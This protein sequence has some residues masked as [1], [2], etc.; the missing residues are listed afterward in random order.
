MLLVAARSEADQRKVQWTFRRP[1]AAR[2]QKEKGRR[3]SPPAFIRK[4]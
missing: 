1:N 2:D 4:T 3:I